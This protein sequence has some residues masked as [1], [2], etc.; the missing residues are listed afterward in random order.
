MFAHHRI[1]KSHALRPTPAWYNRKFTS[2]ALAVVMLFSSSTA[3]LAAVKDRTK[4]TVP[5][6]FRVTSKTPF[7]ISLAWSP[8]SDNSGNFTYMI[9]STGG[10]ATVTL[11]KTATSYTFSPPFY[12]GNSYTLGIQAV[13]AAG[14]YSNPISVSTTTPR[15]TTAP[16]VAPVLSVTD[17][18][19]T[20]V[21]LTW[22]PSQDE[23][24]FLF[25]QVWVNG[26]P[27]Q[28]DPGTGRSITLQLLQPVTTYTFNV[29]ARDYGNNWSPLSAAVTATTESPNSND[30]TPPTTPTDLRENHWGGSDTEINLNWTQSTDDFDEPA[31]IRYDVYVNGILQ[32]TLFGG[33]RQS[34]VY[35]D[36]GPNTIQ[37]F[38][39]D[40]AGNTSAPATISVFF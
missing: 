3:T 25:Y 34:I 20:F 29:R 15:D 6:N 7:S 35:G 39:T 32:D 27:Y 14:N 40:T 5:G 2:T 16:T 36:I 19:S 12:P 11:P 22:T 28:V 10:G 37:V 26:S 23:G 9:W 24:P 13:D 38:A 18:G 4:P 1:E 31:N 21:S 8:S 33:R 17:V 30:T